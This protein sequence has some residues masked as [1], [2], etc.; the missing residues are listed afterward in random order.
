MKEIAVA[1]SDDG[2][3]GRSF[4]F[5]N[6]TIHGAEDGFL[7]LGTLLQNGHSL[8]IK[9]FSKIENC[10]LNLKSYLIQNLT[11]QEQRSS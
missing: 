9:L 2:D 3:E 4:Q 8:K 7:I 1:S 11:N 5:K 10:K 6:L